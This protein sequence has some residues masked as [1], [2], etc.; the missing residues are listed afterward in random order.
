MLTCFLE[1]KLVLSAGRWKHQ[2]QGEWGGKACVSV[3]I[4]VFVW[5]WNSVSDNR[6]T[7]NKTSH[8]KVSPDRQRPAPVYLFG[9]SMSSM[10]ARSFWRAFLLMC[11]P[12]QTFTRLASCFMEYSWRTAEVSGRRPGRDGTGT[13]WTG[14]KNSPCGSW[15]TAPCRSRWDSRLWC[16][17]PQTLCRGWAAGR[18]TSPASWGTAGNPAASAPGPRGCTSS[19]WRSC[20]TKRGAAAAAGG[21]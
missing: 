21:D 9:R 8:V 19:R 6:N 15:W 11:E 18:S 1:L 20:R 17:S 16:R 14:P 13:G 3:T 7:A 4:L 10:A 2:E 5:I 12:R